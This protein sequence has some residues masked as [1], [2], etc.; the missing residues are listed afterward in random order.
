MNGFVVEEK[1]IVKGNF[2]PVTAGF[3]HPFNSGPD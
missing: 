1:G 2:F 3:S